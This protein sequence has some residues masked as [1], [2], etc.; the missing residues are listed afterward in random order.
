MQL[1][2]KNPM[3]R[4]P[5]VALLSVA[6]LLVFGLVFS[7]GQVLADPEEAWSATFGGGDDDAAY[8][9][10]QDTD[11]GFVIAGETQSLGAGGRDVLMVK[12]D[13]G[14]DEVWSATFGG[15]NDDVAYD[16]QRTDDGGYILAGKTHSFRTD[17]QDTAVF[18]DF[19]LIKTDSEGN[20]LW[21]RAY[22]N[23]VLLM[24]DGGLPTSDVARS[25]QQT[26]DGGYVMAGWT[27][28][29]LD[30]EPF[31]SNHFWMIK[32]D[33]AGDEQWRRVFGGTWN[34]EASA[35]RQTSDGGYI[36]AGDTMSPSGGDTTDAWLL[37]TDGDGNEEWSAS[38]GGAGIDMA[39]DVLQSDDGGYVF[40]GLTNSSGEGFSDFWMVKTDPEGNQEWE[41]TFG[42]L[43]RETAHAISRTCD[44]GYVMAGW[45]ESFPPGDHFL[46][47]KVDDEGNLVWDQTLGESAGAYAVQET[48]DGGYILAGWTGTLFGSRDFLL[49]KTGPDCDVPATAPAVAVLENTGPSPISAAAVGFDFVPQDTPHKFLYSG[50]FLSRDNPLPPGEVACTEPIE[51]LVTGSHLDLDQI[52]S[53]DSPLVDEVTNE[54]GSPEIVIDVTALSFDLAYPSAPGGRIA[55]LL[56]F[57]SEPPCASA[58][59]AAPPPAPAPSSDP[60]PK[61][62]FFGTVVSVSAGLLEVNTKGEVIQVATSEDTKIRLPRI[63]NASLSDLAQGD[64]VAVS[65]DEVDGI[66]VA[67]KVHLVSGKTKFRHIPGEVI[68]ISDTEIT[69]QPPGKHAEPIAFNLTADTVTRVHGNVSEA[70]VGSF[71]VV[72]AA[73]DP[74]TGALGVNALEINVTGRKA[75]DPAPAVAPEPQTS[76]EIQGVFGGVNPEGQWIIGDT[77]VAVDKATVIGEGLV[78]GQVLEVEAVIQEDGAFLAQTITTEDTSLVVAAKTKLEGPFQGVDQETGNWIIGGTPVAVVPEADT[79]GV[80]AEGQLVKVK[81]VLQEDG[82]LLARE[83]ENLGD[84]SQPEADGPGETKLEGTFQGLDE[85]GNWIVNGA[86]LAVDPLTRLEGAPA[87]GGRVKVKAVVRQDGSLLASKIKGEEKDILKPKNKAEMRGAIQKV[88]DDGT[89]QVGGITVALS[90]L[91]ELGKTPKVGDLVKV[92]ALVRADGTLIARE[93][94]AATATEADE[95]AE[96]SKVE[97][98]GIIDTVNPDVSLVVN[99]ITVA[100]SALSDIRG[101]LAAGKPVKLEGLLRPDGTLIA[102]EVK[103]RG[104]RPS[105]PVSEAKLKGLLEKV[106]RDKHGLVTSLVVDGLTVDVEALTEGEVDLVAGTEVEIDAVV[107]DGALS[108]SK[109]EKPKKARPTKAAEVKLEGAIDAL[110][111]DNQGRVISVEVNGLQVALGALAKPKDPL[112]VGQLI[113]IDTTNAGGVLQASKVEAKQT[114]RAK[115]KLEEFEIKGTVE[116]VKRDDAGTLV[117]LVV[118]GMEVVAEYLTKLEGSIEAGDEI[119]VKGVVSDGVNLA[120]EIEGPEVEK[121]AS[122]QKDQAGTDAGGAKGQ[123]VSKDKESGEDKAETKE[124]SGSGSSDADKDSSGSG[125]SDD[126]KDSSVSGSSDADKDSSASDSSDADKDSSGSGSS[127]ADKDSSGSGS[128]DADKDSSASDSSDADKDSSDSGS[129]DD[130]EKAKKTLVKEPS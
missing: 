118:D 27:F 90:V 26:A 58:A 62:D 25:V 111:K 102:S 103:G 109:I 130:V 78:V 17:D 70:K 110:Q 10:V 22:G 117:G 61:L 57:V 119:K 5:F 82:S 35:V 33:P 68:A 6:M 83:I 36:L 125:S 40:T 114:E 60:K 23:R 128:S 81:A 12:T 124:T 88:Y 87:V 105:G 73:R 1:T 75:R 85:H 43:T 7:T 116:V 129:S 38:F 86:V 54:F 18:S 56:S 106:N 8:A 65:L 64:T 115:D 9:V 55:G 15:A 112:E 107:S 11:G 32:T 74:S 37:K 108:A 47:V 4:R 46:L 19:W 84:E 92:A 72:G 94:D 126:D 29:R 31:P 76:A 71:V 93:V 95:L 53:F 44:G 30:G 80:P 21:A 42:G 89:I 113:E 48:Q 100:V 50:A 79:D 67:G 59:P 49:L 45:T 69:V 123:A 66:L 41:T 2:I 96:P 97:I 13:A 20:Q 121:E 3:R 34:D 14:G 77:P 39:R 24:I 120:R 98:E 104:S 101:D 122:D 63:P 91:T 28:L 51:Q 127:D 52:G 16:L 99:G